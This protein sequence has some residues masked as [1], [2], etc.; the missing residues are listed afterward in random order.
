MMK[1]SKTSL[2]DDLDVCAYSRDCVKV[3]D[4]VGKIVSFNEDGLRI[5]EIDHLDQVRDVFWPELWPEDVRRLASEG[6]TTA[7]S[8]GVA[9]FKAPCPTAKG[10][11]KW[12]DVTIAAIPGASF[13]FAVIS[14]DIT[15]QYAEE[16]AQR[17]SIERLK[18]VTDSNPD[19]LWDVDL[20]ADRV[21]W[22]EGIQRLFGY[23][24]DQIGEGTSWSNEHI[25]PEDRERVVAGIARA[26]ESDATLWEDEFRYRAADGSYITVLDRGSIIRDANGTAIRFVGV[27]Q[28]VTARNEKTKF[29]EL[30]TAELAHRV[31]NLLAVA[32]ALFQQ[33]LNTCEDKDALG[34]AFGARLLAMANANKSIVKG[35]A[36]AADFHTLVDAQLSPFIS[37]GRLIANGPAIFVS[38][39]IAQP[40]ALVLNELATNALK[41]GALSE[42]A[43][44][45]TLDW[46]LQPAT[47]A[48]IIEWTERDG[49]IV[50]T[51]AH[52]GLGSRLIQHCIPK[53][54]VERRFDAEGF[55]CLIEISLPHKP[56]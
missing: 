55:S 23:G 20:K 27:M 21:W 34:R 1:P 6:L 12:W 46:S 25:H 39:E 36:D 17:S 13:S 10:T 50:Q 29:Q 37:D 43:G 22:S 33:S 44:R 56:H 24:P 5:M 11:L 3:L 48:V 41:Y 52:V 9:S 53:A 28:D 19:I 15:E 31:N 7:R 2:R 26:V 18:T 35:S 14:R 30:V 47:S 45:V 51:P 4:A 32:S 16:I 38:A 8:T 40:I 42:D 49:P 54:K